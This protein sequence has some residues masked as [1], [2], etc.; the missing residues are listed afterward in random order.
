MII[1]LIGSLVF[2][3]NGVACMRNEPT[4]R[5]EMECFQR[6]EKPRPH[7]GQLV[8]AA[9]HADP[10]AGPDEPRSPPSHVLNIAGVA[11]A[12]QMEGWRVARSALVQ[13]T[14]SRRCRRAD[15]D[16]Q[17]P[18]EPWPD[19]SGALSDEDRGSGPTLTD[20]RKTV[21]W[22]LFPQDS[23]YLLGGCGPILPEPVAVDVQI[24]CS[25]D[26]RKHL[27]LACACQ[28][29]LRNQAPR[30]RLL[31]FVPKTF[32]QEYSTGSG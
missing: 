29:I 21:N 27:S 3:L 12:D 22:S 10:R 24:G 31:R 28:G 26:Q 4:N 19:V 1:L 7:G 5:I 6:I 9:E 17:S 23:C 11:I 8:P 2:P 32:A 20:A 18:L 16:Q 13:V 15:S 25:A 30:P 14:M